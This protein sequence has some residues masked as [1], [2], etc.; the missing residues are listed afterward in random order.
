M[1]NWVACVA[2]TALGFGAGMAPAMSSDLP[3]ELRGSLP[4]N[5]GGGEEVDPLSFE[6]GLRYWYALGRQEIAYGGGNFLANDV[7][8]IVEI[9]ARIDDASTDTYLKA[10]AGAAALITG[11]YVTPSAADTISGGNVTYAVA[12]LGYMPIAV[13]DANASFGLGGLIGVQYWNNSPDMDRGNFAAV[14]SPAD[15]TW[16]TTSPDPMFGFSS[17]EN[18]IDIYALRLGVSGQAKLGPFDISGEIAAIPYARV[19]GTLGADALWSAGC[20]AGCNV[21]KASETTIEGAGYGASGELMVG[22]TLGGT[23]AV[24]AGARAWYLLT[25]GEVRYTGATITDATDN[26]AD[27]DYETP[28]TVTMQNFVQDIDMFSQFRGGV[29][30]EITNQF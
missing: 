13:G 9:Y 27:P 24:R 28:G 22:A 5:W 26:D 25:D 23:W 7:S 10:Y 19:T 20:G 1:R 15:V 29:F 14:S 6:L 16:S 17:A 21:Y 2:I 8:N 4:F 18:N 3:G 30:A 12:D 11:N